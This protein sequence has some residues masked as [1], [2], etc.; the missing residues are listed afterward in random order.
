MEISN[1]WSEVLE[2]LIPIFGNFWEQQ[3]GQKDMPNPHFHISAKRRGG[4][5]F[6]VDYF[7]SL[8]Q[9]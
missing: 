6:A 4:F 2:T 1:D 5:F 9:P 8:R 3:N 7:H